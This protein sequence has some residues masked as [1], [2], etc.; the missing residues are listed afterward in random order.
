M[1]FAIE[2]LG[3]VIGLED[4]FSHMMLHYFMMYFYVIT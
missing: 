2:L 4:L 1:W 3:K